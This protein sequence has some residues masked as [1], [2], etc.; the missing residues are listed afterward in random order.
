MIPSTAFHPA[1]YIYCYRWL[2]ESGKGGNYTFCY[3][4][5]IFFS[6]GGLTCY[7]GRLTALDMLDADVVA[8]SPSS[9]Y[10]VLR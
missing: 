2:G 9:V 8:V 4:L 7:V 3:F 5:A 6:S 1:Y 10:R